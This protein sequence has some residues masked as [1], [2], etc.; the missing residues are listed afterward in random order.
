[1]LDGVGY[2][3]GTQGDEHI[4]QNAPKEQYLQGFLL[5]GDNKNPGHG[6]GCF[7]SGLNTVTGGYSD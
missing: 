7:G 1:M 4:Y 2:A 6:W 3:I 5:W